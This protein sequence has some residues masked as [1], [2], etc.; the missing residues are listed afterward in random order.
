MRWL[1][2][3]DLPS[4]DVAGVHLH[5]VRR[6]LG[7][8]AFGANAYSADAGEQLIEEHTE[9]GGGAGEH[10]ELYVV[11]L[12]H[13]TFT[14]DGEDLDAPAGT[15]V[16]CQPG[17]RRGAVAVDDGT[18]ALVIGGKPGAA[19]PI[20]PWEHYFSAAA[21]DDPVRAYERA[22]RGL[23]DWPGHPS[24]H[25]NLACLAALAGLRDE[26]LDHLRIAFEG[27]PKAR[28]WAAEDPDLDSVRDEL[29]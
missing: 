2:L 7:L 15:A 5:L 18:V 19:G 11:V 25:Y 3:G 12:G 24:L 14:V 22:K 17:E 28:G 16:L 20:S 6:P 8:T 4:I 29:P 13:A 23:E 1:S 21:E 10:E 26:A 9:E 27:E